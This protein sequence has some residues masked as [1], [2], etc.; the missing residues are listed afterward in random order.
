MRAVSG[1]PGESLVIAWTAS[2]RQ[3]AS[4]PT[5]TVA[6]SDGMSLVPDSAELVDLDLVMLGVFFSS[7]FLM[8]ISVFGASCWMGI[9]RL[10][11]LK[12]S[13]IQLSTARWPSQLYH[14]V[15]GGSYRSLALVRH[16]ICVVG[17][18]PLPEF[19]AHLSADILKMS[20][21]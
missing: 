7:V 20:G 13:S 14:V 11:F 4:T 9:R 19:L 5:K 8:V 17:A 6:A 18:S 21:R 1:S 16:P 12:T 2:P 15:T 10:S 3:L